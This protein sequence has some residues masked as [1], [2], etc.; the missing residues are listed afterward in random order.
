MKRRHSTFLEGL[1]AVNMSSKDDWNRMFVLGP[2]KVE[3]MKPPVGK[4][5]HVRFRYGEKHERSKEN[6]D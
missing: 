4:I 5:F 2:V 1:H 6:T 3:P